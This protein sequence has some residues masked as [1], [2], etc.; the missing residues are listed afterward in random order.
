MN[1][2]TL[3]SDR[4]SQ[5]AAL[6]LVLVMAV[7]FMLIV[8][9]MLSLTRSELRSSDLYVSTV[10]ADQLSDVAQSVVI[11]QIRKATEFNADQGMSFATQPGAIRRYSATGEYASGH[12]LYSDSKMDESGED[13]E[14]AF[15]TDAPPKNWNELVNQYVDLN[16][17]VVRTGP[18]GK[19]HTYFPI[20]DPRAAFDDPATA[21]R[22]ESV[23]GF[24]FEDDIQG[25]VKKGEADQWRLPMPVE[26]LYVLEDGTLGTLDEDNKFSPADKVSEEN[27]II[28]RIAFWTDDE[29]C[30][31]NINTASEPT[32]WAMPS[33]ADR[34]DWG[35]AKIQ[36]GTGEYQR[37]PGHPATTAL[38][39][40]LFP[41]QQ[42]ADPPSPDS[43]GEMSHWDIFVSRRS[44]VEKGRIY[45]WAPKVQD[46]GSR[47]GTAFMHYEEDKHLWGWNL[48]KTYAYD[49]EFD[50]EAA[51]RERLYAC[52]DEFLLDQDREEHD[53]SF[54]NYEDGKNAIGSNTWVNE[55]ALLR[56]RAFLTAHSRA[57]ETTVFGTPRIAMWPL[58]RN[59]DPGAGYRTHFDQL[60]ARCATLGSISNGSSGNNNAYYFQRENSKSSTHDI[61]LSRNRALLSY[62]QELTSRSAPGYGDSFSR[63]YGEDRNQILVEMFDY[64][65]STNL[66]DPILSAQTREQDSVEFKTYTAGRLTRQHRGTQYLDYRDHESLLKPGHGFVIPS[67]S[68]SLDAKG[69]GRALTLSEVAM[70]FI[71]CADGT[72]DEQN[73][74]RNR[75]DIDDPWKGGPTGKEYSHVADAY[76]SSQYGGSEKVTKVFSNF[77]PNPRDDPYGPPDAIDPATGQRGHPGYK[78]ENWNYCL[79]AN[80]PLEVG[81]KRIQ[82]ML[83]LDYFNIAPGYTP[84]SGRLGVRVKGL[85]NFRV[86]DEPLFPQD[87]AEMWRVGFGPNA[88]W[89]VR[90][91][92]GHGWGGGYIGKR[93]AKRDPMPEDVKPVNHRGH[94]Q[95]PRDDRRKFNHLVTNFIDVD[96]DSMTFGANGPLEIEI[97]VQQEEGDPVEVLQKVIVKYPAPHAI[98]S[99]NLVLNEKKG[100]RANNRLWD[101]Y[102]PP[103]ADW[104]EET[105]GKWGK[106]YSGGPQSRKFWSF[107][108]DGFNLKAEG[109]ERKGGR[110]GSLRWMGHNWVYGNQHDVVYS[111]VPW[112][113]DFRI[114]AARQLVDA[115]LN[116]P[117]GQTFVPARGMPAVNGEET[118]FG[119]HSFEHHILRQ[120]NN[121]AS[122]G[123]WHHYGNREFYAPDQLAALPWPGHNHR[124][125]RTPQFP[126]TP[127]ATAVSRRYG[128]FDI[129]YGGLMGGAFINKPDEGNLVHTEKGTEEGIQLSFEDDPPAD[130]WELAYQERRLKDYFLRIPYFHGGYQESGS[131][132]FSPNR[133][134]SSPVML[135]SLPSGVKQQD[136]WRTLL[137]RPDVNSLDRNG[138]AATHPGAKSPPDHL[139]LDLFWMPVVEPYAI[140]EPFSTA[141]KINLNYQILPFTHIR[142]AT[143]LHGLFKDERIP[144]LPVGGEGEGLGRRRDHNF[145]RI[146]YGNAHARKTYEATHWH[147]RWRGKWLYRKIDPDET[148]EDFDKKFNED[149]TLFRS[150]SQICEMHLVPVVLPMPEKARFDE[151]R[152]TDTGLDTEV[153]MKDY[154]KTHRGTADNLRE[155]PYANIYGRTTTQTNT[156]RIHYRVQRIKKARQSAYDSFDP[157]LDSVAAEKRGSTLIE[158]YIDPND[159]ELPDFTGD[160][161]QNL[162]SFYRFR[163]LNTRTF[164]L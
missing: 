127:E 42:F 14:E 93:V 112:H 135:G 39:P 114:L 71:C 66:F 158:R 49:Q 109:V 45:D 143:G 61:G 9:S 30:K 44:A 97:L 6:L 88:H 59:S 73:P 104:D 107:Y 138:A 15:A 5:G 137:F 123:V 27:G 162:D 33:L 35:W 118:R 102:Q 144:S 100:R 1:C 82:G 136:P 160:S 23:E 115:D 94:S 111:M 89:S 16:E 124:S 77:P 38:S 106:Y 122:H 2:F 126:K 91:G 128:D 8:L 37:F 40:V 139:L 156:W 36:P 60:I 81:K 43:N 20:I 151:G 69:L 75:P 34:S 24:S 13:G 121:A 56:S 74:Y 125:Q 55:D 95:E 142:R 86:N 64:I 11:T 10:H 164:S 96:Q 67:V 87:E 68:E 113:G 154:W 18:D 28:G 7:L 78:E 119:F 76:Y 80:T 129:G 29:S 84:I 147:H 99:P 32:Y 41:N 31:I 3:R 19:L 65:R 54:T 22:Q 47:S 155:R 148:L 62:L 140:S 53:F 132:H 79:E 98:P 26:W 72:P 48:E 108:R 141:G 90:N 17:P 21:D 50:P 146:M 152:F 161:T 130:D 120:Y 134:I 163:V 159:P 12:K 110:M 103:P 149:F 57:P 157:D 70:H 117:T 52:V 85:S 116:G 63:K 92:L 83:H 101:D 46:V 145:E 105:D 150:A 58:H 51:K 133:L 25:V 131:G 4:N 153:R